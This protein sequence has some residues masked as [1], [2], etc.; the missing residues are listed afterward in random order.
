MG[1]SLVVKAQVLGHET[2]QVLIAQ[3]QDVVE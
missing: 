2:Q 1:P 3:D